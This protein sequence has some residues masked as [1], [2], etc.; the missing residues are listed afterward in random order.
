M[1][2]KHFLFLVSGI[3]A[4]VV[5]CLVAAL[6]PPIRGGVADYRFGFK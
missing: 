2:K 5:L 6:H 1:M 4:G 3:V